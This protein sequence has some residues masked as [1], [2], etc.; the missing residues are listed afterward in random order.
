MR[1][2]FTFLSLLFLLNNLFSQTGTLKGS[3]TD[4]STGEPLAGTTVFIIG[5]YSGTYTDA[6]GN[7]ELKGI[8]PGD[9]SV[10]FS[11]VGYAEK[12]YNGVNI[13]A[14]GST[15]LVVSMNSSI[16]TLGEVEIVGQ[17][18][19]I[20]LES[21]K[22]SVKIGQEEI[23]EMSVKNVQEIA[24][25]QVGVNLSPD[26]IQIRGGR[27]YETEYLVDGINAQDPLAGTGFG[28]DV[29]A[30]AVNNVEVITGGT[31]AEFGNGSSGVILTRIR[32]GGKRWRA[33][34]TYRR[35]NLGFR[36]NQGPSWNTDEGELSI[37]GPIIKDKLS[38]FT[39]GSFYMS[40]DYF[41]AVATQ[42]HS[43]LFTNDSLWAPRQ[44]NRWSHTLKL[45]W[46]IRPGLKI[47]LTN[48][49]SLNINQSTRSLQIVGNDA[50]VTPGFQFPFS[51]NMDNANTY[52]HSSNLSVVNVRALLTPQW[53]LDA[54]AGRLFTSL[55]VDANGLPFR[56]QTVDQL[57]DPSSIVTDPVAVFNPEGDVVYV[58]P[59]PGLINNGGIAT[60]WHDHYV[61]EYT[62]K[63]K[64]TFESK[65]KVHYL[66]L[67]QEHK[68]QQYQW[69]DVERPWVGAPIKIN[70][71]LTTP[72]TSLG[73][74]SD[75]WN[76]RPAT[77]GFYVSDEI[78]YKGIIANIGMRL[79]YWAPGTFV[80]DAVENPSAPVLDA[81]RESYKEQTFGLAGRRWKARLL[82]RLRV[83]FPVTENNVLYFNYSHAMRL[84]HPR[85][86]YAG[87][88]PVF[89]DRSFLSNLGNPNL[90]PEVTVSYEVGLKSQLTKDLALTAT[91]FYN[92]KFDY[93]VSRRVE[94]R[95]QTGRFVEK[96][97]Y[98]NQDYAR[99]R[100]LELGLTRRI[101]KWLTTSLT[102]SY[103]IATGK[104][105]T[106]AESALQIK[107]Q[108][109]VNTTKEQFL[110]WDRPFD[111]KFLAILKPDESVVIGRI[112]L[113]GFRL[114]VTSTYKSG[115]RYTPNILWRINDDS[116]RPEYIPVVNQPFAKVGS[117][118][119]WTN[120]KLTRDF[121]FGK[122]AYLALNF[123]VENITNFKSAAIVNGVTG[124]G[125]EYGDPLPL[126]F[127]DPI[128][129]DPQD[130]GLPP[131][132]PA[133]YL[134]PRHIWFGAEFGF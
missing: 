54:S 123:E 110:A 95:D 72:S 92:D 16:T 34:G 6:G 76:A 78:Q 133:R 30:G 91:A 27:I 64:F 12:I 107:A 50:V 38:F 113:E 128:Y 100:G 69:I 47:T 127:R 42:L 5:T 13:A 115:L 84:P 65:D 131:E 126:S 75:Y 132:N 96:T 104:S 10:K 90:N 53:T 101:G 31:D 102:G 17:K 119:F 1:Y 67:G 81:I 39:S 44:D 83:S 68:E 118:W 103:Q 125:Y 71:T 59:G 62:L 97:F 121:H 86:V 109:F 29:G 18:T 106:A 66:S 9:Y 36:V 51:L 37:G 82:P 56:T 25:L 19:L 46:T 8:K 74:T 55:R 134:T 122:N 52:T 93:I 89:Q 26:G 43:S 2:T 87:L 3:V 88:D 63:T 77:G 117:P 130:R 124:K 40:D 120:M 112:P 4:E 15:T 73:S 35:D 111:I 80:D 57:Y 70:D 7:F 114:M 22:S 32:E 108:G 48:Q 94:V 129:P 11:Y 45:A 116:G 21:G 41:R 79:N 60:R 14:S 99:I 33:T 24:A 49:H 98:I 20:D 61:E 23:A 85:F 28:V 58:F 105:N